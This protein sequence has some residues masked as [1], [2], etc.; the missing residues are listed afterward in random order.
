M[1]YVTSVKRAFAIGMNGTFGGLL[2]AYLNY[3]CNADAHARRRG[4]ATKEEG[5]VDQIV[6]KLCRILCILYSFA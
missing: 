3:A 5:K 1:R 2:R 6:I 4:R